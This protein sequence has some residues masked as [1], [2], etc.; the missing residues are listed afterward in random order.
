MARYR[1]LS[2]CAV[3]VLAVQAYD[4]RAQDDDDD[5]N[6]G[7]GGGRSITCLGELGNTRV[8]GD[9]D[10]VGRCRLNGTEVRGDVTMFSGGSLTA[11][12]ARIRGDLEGSRAD[13]VDL[14]N[15]RVDGRVRLD[16]MVGDASV[17][18]LT[19]VQGN[20]ELTANRSAFEIS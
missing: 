2:V 12:D 17:I 7:P 16:G 20:V 6:D 18:A 8:E 13:F 19:D 15:S 1:W 14:S 5:D 3:T 9:V 11:R 10:V 4:A